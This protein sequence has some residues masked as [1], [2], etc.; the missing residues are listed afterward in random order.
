MQNP[1]MKLEDDQ[2]LQLEPFLRGMGM[3]VARARNNRK[4]IDAI[5]WFISNKYNAWVDMPP[6]YGTRSNI[7]MRF[8]R[9]NESD[10]WRQLADSVDGDDIL[11]AMLNRI[12]EY[13]D[14]EKR[15]VI[16]K[17]EKR[18]ICARTKANLYKRVEHN[19]PPETLRST[20]HW[21]GLVAE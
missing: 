21:V 8:R 3:G 9:W 16:L 1:I 14:H 11:M 13:A 20:S 17:R 2:W 12:A 4:F 6:E 10:F 7:Y 5:L 15:R 19:I 18:V